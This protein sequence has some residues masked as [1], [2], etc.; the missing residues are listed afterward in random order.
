MLGGE[1][2]VGDV[3]VDIV[4]VGRLRDFVT[5]QGEDVIDRLLTDVERVAVR[6]APGI[7]WST[8]AGRI[9]AKEAT[10]KLL[11]RR[12]ETARWSEIEIY[13]GLHGEPYIRL[14]GA[15]LAAARR[16]G[17]NGVLIS[18]SHEKQTAIA[19][20]IATAVWQPWETPWTFAKP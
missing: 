17:I 12:G 14:S 4:D 9:A 16:H 13:H 20:A 18:I 8:F 11:G 1:A 3:G 6:G 10:K 19:V 7:N 5:R 2:L 15:T